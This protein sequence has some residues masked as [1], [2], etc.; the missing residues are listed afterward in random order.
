M[1]KICQI[2]FGRWG[3]KVA[4]SFS[5]KDNLL[6][7]TDL[8][9][10]NNNLPENKSNIFYLP[11]QPISVI[12]KEF[13]PD[14]YY[15]AL[16]QAVQRNV[17]V[18]IPPHIPILVEKPA[19]GNSWKI[20][21]IETYRPLNS[22]A[23]G[24]TFLQCNGFQYIINQLKLSNDPICI[25]SERINTNGPIR[26]DINCIE[27][28]GIHDV[29]LF[30]GLIKQKYKII[31]SDLTKVEYFY[32]NRFGARFVVN[33]NNLFLDVT[34][35]WIGKEKKR[36]WYVHFNNE[37][38][39]WNAIKDIVTSSYSGIAV[40][41]NLQDKT[42]LQKQYDLLIKWVETGIFPVQLHSLEDAKICAQIMEQL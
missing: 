37:T 22:I 13:C 38:L 33:Y 35:S 6:Y 14:A 28:F 11:Y 9:L 21:Y 2:G 18:Q 4:N 17:I 30:V 27:D 15:L 1:V 39:Y 34:V 36:D 12:H 16:P 10:N 26:T 41:Q 24:H 40:P 3:K 42:P 25:Y 23:V 5:S 31:S 7:I 32:N 29:S 8:L 19:I 20:G